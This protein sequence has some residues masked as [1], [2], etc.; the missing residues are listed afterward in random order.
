[1]ARILLVALLAAA[2]GGAIVYG[3]MLYL[4]RNPLQ[5][6]LQVRSATATPVPLPVPSPTPAPLPLPTDAPIP[7]PTPIILAQPAPS[8]TA[9]VATP[10]PGAATQTPEQ[11][12][13][14]NAFAECDGQ[15]DGW[16]KNHRAWGA[17]SAIEEGRQTVADIRALVVRYCG[18]VF[19]E[20]AVVVQQPTITP[21]IRPTATASPPPTKTPPPPTALPPT[22]TLPTAAAASPAD[23]HIAEKRHMLELINAER[24]AAGVGPVALGDNIAAQLHADAALAN[25]FSSHW[26]LDGLKPYM[27]YSLAGGY[28]SNAENGSGLDY[29]IKASDGYRAKGGIDPRIREA[30]RQWMASPGHRRNILDPHHKSVSIGI[31]WDTYNTAM[32]QHFEG[33]YVQYDQPPAIDRGVLTLAGS[34]KNGVRFN[35]GRD[36]GVQIYHD[37]PTHELTPGQIAQTY[38]YD[39]GRRVAALREPLTGGYRWTTHEFTTTYNPCPDP[40][41]VA[42]SVPAPR[43]P[44]EAHQ[45]WQRAYNASNLRQPESITVPWVTANRWM[46]SGTSF[47]VTANISDI[48]ERHGDGVYSLILWGKIDGTAIVISQYS[49]FHGV[50]PPDTYGS[51]AR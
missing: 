8:P 26:G 3:V 17:R 35:Q 48:L 46:A 6:D 12:V 37:P 40:Y 23:K 18:G 45:A 2:I 14:I 21:S 19:P 44:A 27:R 42:D 32:Y 51:A 7:T 9:E 49:I 20:L 36:L 13:V 34:V 16:H 11:R 28:Q 38:C 10:T 30:M 50:T 39:N 15:Y 22:A 24:E 4:E 25:C 41:E 43:S 29:C 47:A 1:M 5:V 31:A 33:E